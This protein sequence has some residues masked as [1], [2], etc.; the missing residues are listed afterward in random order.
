MDWKSE[1]ELEQ[2]APALASKIRS[3]AEMMDL[4]GDPVRV[5]RARASAEAQERL[6]EQ[7][8]GL[9]GRR[10][11]E[12]RPGGSWHE[13]GLAVD[14]GIIR[15]LSEPNWAPEDIA[16][17]KMG[18]MGKMLGLF[19]GG[20]FEHNPDR[21]HFQLTGRFPVSPDDEVRQIFAIGG[22]P[23]VWQASLLV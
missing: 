8:R 2:V 14:L 6:W 1:G 3:L 18:N 4:A 12:A 7:G 11:T 16:W 22:A 17:A 20:D 15:L 23:A 13:F 19:W 21:P 9:G 5:I 10:V